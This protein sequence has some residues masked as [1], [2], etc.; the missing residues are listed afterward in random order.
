M[1]R[2]VRVCMREHR[3]GRIEKETVSRAAREKFH[4]RIGLALVRLEDQRQL[5]ENGARVRLR[6]RRCGKDAFGE[7][8]RIGEAAA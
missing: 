5:P 3:A 1:A 8:A 6:M 7:A 2:P 4:L